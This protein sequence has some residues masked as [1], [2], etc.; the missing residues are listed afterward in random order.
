[1]S[2]SLTVLI[3]T[4]GRSALLERTLKSVALSERPQG[5]DGCI[6]VENGLQEGAE[7]IVS[8]VAEEYPNARICYL[9]HT[10]A[11]KSA[12]LNAALA[13]LPDER[14][15][16]LLDDDIRVGTQ[17]L[18]AYADAAFRRPSHYY[19]GPVDCDYERVP[20]DWLIPSLPMSARGFRGTDGINTTFFLGCNWAAFAGD[21]R[22]MG[23]FDPNHGPGSPTGARGQESVAQ[24][25]LRSNGV[26]PEYVPDALVWH[27]VPLERCSVAWTV[28]R[29]YQV[30]LM[31]GLRE[32]PVPLPRRAYLVSRMAVSCVLFGLRGNREQAC[33]RFME[34][35]R[36]GGALIATA[37]S[38]M[39]PNS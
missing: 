38:R 32:N 11:N 21:L 33:H 13:G 30:G 9:H 1:M 22:H 4:H 24:D 34:F 5:Y 35:V 18:K 37:R 17:A 2:P 10:Q 23:G 7:S 14:L 19:G 26:L 28:Q 31:A 6:V 3:P 27:Y 39:A 12:A 8:R 25:N 36:H 29:K 15:V 20:P 16:I